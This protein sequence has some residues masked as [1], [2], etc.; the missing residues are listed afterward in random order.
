MPPVKDVDKAIESIMEPFCEH[1]EDNTHAFWDYYEMGGR[2]GG[3]KM[4][5]N[6]DKKKIE[7]FYAWLKDEK[8]MVSGLVVGKQSISTREQIRIVDAKWKE[9][10]PDSGFDSCPLFAHSNDNHERMFGDIMRLGDIKKDVTCARAIIARKPYDTNAPKSALEADYMIE[11]SIWNGVTWLKGKIDV[12]VFNALKEYRKN[13]RN[14]SDE[15]RKNR[16]PK[17]DWLVIT[18]DYHS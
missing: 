15:A 7:D 6:L 17:K 4:T 10:F 13:I 9:I 1:D 11:D 2:W 5:E 14:Y 16:T 8:V 18:I 12:S 3:V